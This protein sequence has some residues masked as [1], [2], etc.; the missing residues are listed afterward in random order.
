M[1]K[2]VEIVPPKNRKAKGPKLLGIAERKS[3]LSLSAP[4]QLLL[5]GGTVEL[6]KEGSWRRWDNKHDVR[7]DRRP[8]K[9]GGDQLH[10]RNRNG[11]QWAYRHTGDR[12]EAGKYTLPANRD[13]CDIVRHYFGVDLK[14]G[15]QILVESFT[16][17][18]ITAIFP[19]GAR[20]AN[21][22]LR[23]STK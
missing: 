15:V 2:L 5:E 20:N 23:T 12:S 8:E 18:T 21:R 1:V 7:L 4:S 22:K 19:P 6:L 3:V 13:V 10:I 11:S 16:G 17:D 9:M 14:E